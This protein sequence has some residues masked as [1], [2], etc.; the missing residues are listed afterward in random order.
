MRE[1]ITIRGLSRYYNGFLALDNLSLNVRWNEDVALL[2]PNGAQGNDLTI[3]EQHF[4]IKF[5]NK[6][7]QAL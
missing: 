5:M 3:V 2:G 1:S 4:S 7:P 6:Q